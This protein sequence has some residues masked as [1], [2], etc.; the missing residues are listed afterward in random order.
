MSLADIRKR[1]ARQS[2]QPHREIVTPV[3]TLAPKPTPE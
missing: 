2:Y 1:A 3:A